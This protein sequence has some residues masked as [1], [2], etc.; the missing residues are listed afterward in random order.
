MSDTDAFGAPVSSRDKAA[1]EALNRAET[2]L[3]GYFA[4]PLAEIDAALAEAPDFVMG[5]CFR[6]G[7]FL[8]SS[9]A[10]AEPELKRSLATLRRLAASA[11]EREQ[12]HI[13][14][15]EAWAERDFHGASEAYGHVLF[16]FPRDIIALQF[17]HQTDFLL[18]QATM[19]RDR[20]ARVLPEWSEADPE[21]AYLL[22]MYAFGLE[23]CGHFAQAEETGRRAVAMQPRDAWAYHAV[24]HVC[25]MQG[26]LDDGIAW[27]GGGVDDWA[28]GNMFAFHNFWHLAL[29]HLERGEIDKVLALYD[30]SIR[31]NNSAVAMEMLDAASM[32]WRLKL[33]GIDVGRRWIE[34]A[35]LYEAMAEDAYYPF[36]DAHAMMAF[37]ATGRTEAQRRLVAALRAAAGDRN[38]S[39][40][41]V[42]D[43]G[44]PV[45]RALQRFGEGDYGEAFDLL[46]DV[47]K[48][49]QAFGGSNAQR[50]VLSLTLLEAAI[51]GGDRAAAAG[52]VNERLAAKPASPFAQALRRQV[53]KRRAAA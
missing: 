39:A 3:L 17:A 50:D 37:V 49:A 32:L 41:I 43:V 30:N 26:Q 13:R 6:A 29:Y 14:A 15:I 12:G 11:N 36:N 40:R 27:L 42:R 38:S 8:V 35:D 52:L 5:H 10:G 9:E 47:R 22:G 33:R 34:L 25:E 1:V 53:A 2:L 24:A 51:R 48:R 7:L 18:G 31:P 44:L 28:P 46:L 20:V 19:L 16:D 45:A 4:D 21:Y 23:E